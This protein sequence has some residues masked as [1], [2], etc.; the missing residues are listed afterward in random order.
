MNLEELKKKAT[1]QKTNICL[2]PK[3]VGQAGRGNGYN[4][5]E[6]MGLSHETFN[7]VRVGDYSTHICAYILLNGI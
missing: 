6:E 2:I 5:F 3:P 7:L 4:L 1:K